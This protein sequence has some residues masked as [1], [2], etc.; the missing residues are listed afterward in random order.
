MKAYG[1]RKSK[2]LTNSSV[3]EKFADPYLNIMLLRPVGF[4]HSFSASVLYILRSEEI[5][6]R[7]IKNKKKEKEKGIV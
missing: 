6:V 1:T 7:K 2:I 4:F 3:L 5:E